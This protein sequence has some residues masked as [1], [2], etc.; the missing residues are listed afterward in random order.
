MISKDTKGSIIRELS[1]LKNGLRLAMITE[2]VLKF[3]IL[4]VGILLIYGVL[5]FFLGFPLFVR[6]VISVLGAGALLYLMIKF[7]VRLLRINERDAAEFCDKSSSDKRKTTLSAFE[8]MNQSSSQRGVIADFLVQK[9]CS[10]SATKIASIETASATQAKIHLKLFG[11][12]AIAVFVLII[13][14]IVNFKAFILIGERIALPWHDSPIYS[15]YTF[16]IVPEKPSVFYGEGVDLSVDIRGGEVTKDV[17]LLVKEGSNVYETLCFKK[18]ENQYS[19]KIQHVTQPVDVAFRVGRARS[20]WKR[21]TPLLQ[22]KVAAVECIITPPTYS[23]KMDKRFFLRGQQVKALKDSKILLIVTSN[24]PLKGGVAHVRDISGS[25]YEDAIEGQRQ[26]ARSVV[27]EWPVEDNALIEITLKDVAGNSTAKPFTFNQRLLLD[28]PP[29][30]VLESPGGF[31]MATPKATLPLVGEANDDFGLRRLELVRTVEGFRYRYRSIPLLDGDK[32]AGFEEE[33]DLRGLG[34]EA[35][36]T[37][38]LYLEALDNHPSYMGV[39]TSDIARVKVITEEEYAHMIRMRTTSKDFAER[40]RALAKV[41]EDYRNQV[42]DLADKIKKG[43]EGEE[44]KENLN[45]LQA[46]NNELKELFKKMG[47]DFAVFDE[48]KSLLKAAESVAAELDQIDQKLA[49]SKQG[50]PEIA[51]KTLNDIL[52]RMG[53]EQGMQSTMEK[54]KLKA[55]EIE[56]ISNVFALATEFMKVLN[57]QKDISH[58]FENYLDESRFRSASKLKRLSEVQADNF[59]RLMKLRDDLYL[60]TTR[61]PEG[62]EQLGDQARQFADA[63]NECKALVHMEDA[64]N[65]ADEGGGRAASREAT[66]AKEKLESLLNNSDNNCMSGLCKGQMPSFQLPRYQ[67]TLNQMI[68]CMSLGM[69]QGNSQGMNYGIGMG[70]GGA[71]GDSGYAVEGQSFLD[72]PIYGPDRMQ[73]GVEPSGGSGFSGE[74]TDGKSGVPVNIQKE[75][76]QLEVSEK[77]EIKNEALDLNK[78]PEKYKDAVIKYF[79]YSN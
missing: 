71:G 18:T 7:L 57:A 20:K 58:K 37:L 75:R 39:N 46:K 60:K 41:L 68:Q 24:R 2:G 76:E 52:K 4:L 9:V 32:T 1:R 16:K 66:L 8:L 69:G 45:H 31:M 6:L 59:H 26:S 61:L 67:E 23:K 13:L 21:V 29:Q 12:L 51:Q 38:E 43:L 62:Y 65:Y 5:D 35:G 17:F 42:E 22:P 25:G 73:I 10:A 53:Q 44:L 77:G 55:E 48:E 49:A 63:I 78:V 14:A 56:R 11:K 34:V 72:V 30:V 70:M 27:F 50:G 74:G 47:S 19:Q 36:Q 15:K 54:E 64:K 3:L 33:L 28:T 40:Y 79:K